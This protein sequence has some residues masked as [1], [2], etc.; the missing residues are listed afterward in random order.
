MIPVYAGMTNT[1][2]G[3]ISYPHLL[4]RYKESFIMKYVSLLIF[5]S[6]FALYTHSSLAAIE[7]LESYHMAQKMTPPLIL[8]VMS[9][10][11]PRRC[12]HKAF[13]T[14]CLL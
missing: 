8:R 4:R 13:R 11:R 3:K 9:M 5:V 2:H 1:L 10:R 6:C 14:F 7:I 12:R